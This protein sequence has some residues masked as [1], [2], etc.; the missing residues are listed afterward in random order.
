MVNDHSDLVLILPSLPVGEE[1]LKYRKDLACSLVCL[2]VVCLV[3]V[4]IEDSPVLD[5]A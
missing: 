2:L 3:A 4:Q 5:S 1:L